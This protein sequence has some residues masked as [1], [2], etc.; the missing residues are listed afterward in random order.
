MD[1]ELCIAKRGAIRTAEWSKLKDLPEE[2]HPQ[3][4]S[5]EPELLGQDEDGNLITSAVVA[6]KGRTTLK[7]A[8]TTTKAESLGL[9]TLRAALAGGDKTTLFTWRPIF[10]AKHYGDTDDAKQKSFRRVRESLAGK[11]LI[12]IE[13][14]HYSIPL[15]PGRT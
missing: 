4:F 15:S 10:Y 3:E 12:S 13:G 5:L 14:D 1:A 2:P 9:D 8:I 6:W 7:A 11:G